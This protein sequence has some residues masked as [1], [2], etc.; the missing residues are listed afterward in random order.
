MHATAVSL[1]GAPGCGVTTLERTRGVVH[2]LVGEWEHTGLASGSLT[3]IQT[4]NEMHILRM[5]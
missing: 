1:G 5:G 4:E 3:G 2:S